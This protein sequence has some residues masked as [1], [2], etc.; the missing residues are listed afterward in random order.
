MKWIQLS[1]L[2][3]SSDHDNPQNLERALTQTL[4]VAYEHNQIGGTG[5]KWN[6]G[7]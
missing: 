3:L 7:S 5:A 2:P 4:S 1:P 6:K